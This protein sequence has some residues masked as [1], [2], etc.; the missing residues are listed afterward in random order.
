MPWG[1]TTIPTV[2]PAI[3]SPVSQP[4]SVGDVGPKKFSVRS[5]G[6]LTVPGEPGEQGEQ[7]EQVVDDLTEES[8]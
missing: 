5:S 2:R 3:T 8:A 1:T 6:K 4:R 7:A